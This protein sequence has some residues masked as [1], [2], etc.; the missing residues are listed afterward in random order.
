LVL[1]NVDLVNATLL[2]G[3]GSLLS[4][5]RDTIII[6]SDLGESFLLE[7]TIFWDM[8]RGSSYSLFQAVEY[9][10]RAALKYVLCPRWGIRQDQRFLLSTHLI[11]NGL[12]VILLKI[13]GIRIF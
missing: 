4:I 9:G 6:E 10:R 3:A 7:I 5:Y 12:S 2:C 8:M 13:L 1:V 11:S